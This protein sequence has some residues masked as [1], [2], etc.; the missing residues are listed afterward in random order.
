MNK[1]NK[2]FSTSE[3]YKADIVKTKLKERG[4][5]AIILDKTDSAYNMFGEKEVYVNRDNTTKAIKIIKD[6][7]SFT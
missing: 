6:E 5:S 1:W 2:I 3:L 4:I 7:I